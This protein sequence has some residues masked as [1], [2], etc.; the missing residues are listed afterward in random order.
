MA[1]E[2]LLIVGIGA[3]G[4]TIA[5]R[6]VSAGIP[7]LLA[8]RSIESANA[9]RSTGLQVSGVGG[10]ATANSVQV[11][12]IE[13]YVQEAKFDLILVATKAH[14]ALE[15]APFLVTLLSPGGT[16]LPIQNGSVP[17]LLASRFGE[18]TVLGGLSNIG[19]TMLEPGA[20]EQRNDGHLLIGELSDRISDRTEQISGL[21]GKA[22]QVRVSKNMRGAIWSKL[23]LNCSVTTIG[24]ICG[25]TMRQYMTSRAGQEVF[26][27]TYDEALSTALATGVQPERMMVDPIPPGWKETSV[28]GNAYDAWI[29]QVMG[30]YG[31]VKSSMLQ[32]FERRRRTEIDF[33]NG[34]VAQLGGKAGVPVNLNAAI[35]DLVHQIEQG[36]SEPHPTRLKEL[37][38]Q[39]EER[40]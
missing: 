38:E 2:R 16:L 15:I 6:A 23:I 9:L 40:A 4:G 31:D 28:S 27:R 21:L 34:Y 33:I 24:A 11:A 8:T 13:E 19:A 30:G 22:I 32:D 5:A 26:R 39:V 10:K 7:V 14:A 37:L 12:P 17:E 35:T 20:Y 3:L 36:K 18:N 1:M 25:Q 29:D